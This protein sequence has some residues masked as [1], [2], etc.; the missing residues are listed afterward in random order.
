MTLSLMM[1]RGGLASQQQRHSWLVSQTLSLSFE[2]N[3][4]LYPLIVSASLQYLDFAPTEEATS[5]RL[6]V[7]GEYQQFLVLALVLVLG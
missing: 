5:L 7:S 2:R 6:Q 3:P 1:N 4:H